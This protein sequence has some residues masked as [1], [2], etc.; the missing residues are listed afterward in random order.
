MHGFRLPELAVLVLAIGVPVLISNLVA[1]KRSGE[2]CESGDERYKG[3]AGW[4][5][6]FCLGL[7]VLG[8]L[9]MLKTLAVGY[10][11]FAGYF[12][13]F[14]GL[15]VVTVI[16]TLLSLGIMA[17]SIYA[18][19]GLWRIRPGAVKVAKKY[20]LYFLGYH[21]FTAYLPFMAHLPS[22]ATEAIVAQVVKDSFRA[23][24]YVAIWYSY[25]NKS[26]RVRATYGSNPVGSGG[27]GMGFFQS[28]NFI[29][30]A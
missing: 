23:I 21:A 11:E 19:V 9:V 17:F 14:P 4:L 26:L 2:R 7:T 15:F 13:E 29:S 10:R 6:I 25:L 24:M 18:G 8:P 1:R 16:N 12:G 30:R 20:L 22:A 27:T 28:K 3:V 5:L